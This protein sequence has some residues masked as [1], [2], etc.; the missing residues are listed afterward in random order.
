MAKKKETKMVTFST[1]LS[2]ETK[3]LLERFCKARGIRINYLVEQAILEYIEDEMDR[4]IIEE[5]ELEELVE[6]KKRA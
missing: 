6:W 4:A 1:S 3:N 5:R 2:G